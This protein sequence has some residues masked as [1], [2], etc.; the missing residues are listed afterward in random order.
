MRVS[1][2]AAVLATILATLLL[3]TG[4][5]QSRQGTTEGKTY[6]PQKKGSQNGSRASAADTTTGKPSPASDA[7]Q[8]EAVKGQSV[9]TPGAPTAHNPQK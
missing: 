2:S 8:T 5:S 4:C 9:M 3:A 7:G 6:T 1:V